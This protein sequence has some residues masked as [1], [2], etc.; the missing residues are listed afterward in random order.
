MFDDMYDIAEQLCLKWARY[1][2]DTPVNVV[3][4]FTR[5]TL[6]TLALCAMGYRF[7]SFYLNEELHPYVQSMV[8]VLL[9]SERQ[10]VLPDFLVAM[11]RKAVGQ[12]KSDVQTMS[13]I[14]QDIIDKRHANPNPHATDLLHYMLHGHDPKTGERLSDEEIIWNLNTF[15]IAG[16]ETSSGLLSFALYYLLDNPR[17]L[18]KARAEVDSVV[19]DRGKLN[20][21]SLQNLPY[22]EAILKETLRLQPPAAAFMVRPLE[23]GQVLGGKYLLKST[24][25]ITILLH[26]V[27]RDPSVWGHDA[28]EFKP[29]RMT[30]DKFKNLPLNSWKPFGNGMRSCIG[31]E[32]AM[33]ETKLVRIWTLKFEYVT[34]GYSPS[35]GHG[36]VTPAF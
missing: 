31:R 32:F 35:V 11:R 34:F 18:E 36:H 8:R 24:E 5:L 3:S 12:F 25:T 23:E 30:H 4:D 13:N 7:N 1:G 22:I 27:H 10:A 20:A 2:P 9:E 19:G 15:L 14:C 28:D 33:Q 29:E 6:D 26:K 17:V 16:H 21:R